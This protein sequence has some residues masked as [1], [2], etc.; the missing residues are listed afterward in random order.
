MPYVP[1][2][3]EEEEERKD[4][5]GEAEEEEEEADKVNPSGHPYCVE[6][7]QVGIDE[8]GDAGCVG[9]ILAV[10]LSGFLRW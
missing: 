10:A 1:L 8:F 7:W 6:V 9:R 2:L 3:E 4:G 5:K